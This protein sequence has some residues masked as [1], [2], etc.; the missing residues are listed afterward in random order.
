MNI[1]KIDN[2]NCYIKNN[3]NIKNNKNITYNNIVNTECISSNITLNYFGK[4]EN[5][6]T[7]VGFPNGLSASVYKTDNYE[8]ANPEYRVRYIDKEGNSIDTNVQINSV[9]PSNATYLEMLAYSTYSDIQGM[10][11]N[12]YSNCL[13]SANGV[14]GEIVYD[15][16]SIN[17]KK[18]YMSM[19]EEFMQLQ[20]DCNNLAGYLSFKK[21]YDF[22]K[23]SIKS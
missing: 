3:Q 19:V 18:D 2:S 6:L 16:D 9:D 7:C 11:S 5:A 1:S 10:T 13:Q 12:A 22:M 14:N 17:T 4:N 21:F 15:S 23:A 8:Q 20:Y